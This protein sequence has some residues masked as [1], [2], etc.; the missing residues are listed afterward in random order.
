MI[1]TG[2]FVKEL[3]VDSVSVRL[4]IVLAGDDTCIINATQPSIYAR[5][6]PVGK[7][8]WFTRDPLGW[9]WQQALAGWTHSIHVSD[10]DMSR[11]RASKSL[12]QKVHASADHTRTRDQACAQKLTGVSWLLVPEHGC[13]FATMR[14]IRTKYSK[15]VHPQSEYVITC[16]AWT[17]D[18]IAIAIESGDVCIRME[19]M[20]IGLC[21][22]VARC[23]RAAWLTSTRDAVFLCGR[24]RNDW[25]WSYGCRDVNEMGICFEVWD[26]LMERRRDVANECAIVEKAS[27]YGVINTACLGVPW[28]ELASDLTLL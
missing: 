15:S 5:N 19:T 26:D 24:G 28:P 14:R 20:D 22:G 16:A 12:G 1:P 11:W 8:S 25:K 21:A 23:Y 13:T 27:I 6:D 7:A 9:E 17:L 3:A 2:N 4:P 10:N 18:G